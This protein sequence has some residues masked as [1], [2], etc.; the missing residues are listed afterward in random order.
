MSGAAAGIVME[1]WQQMVLLLLAAALIS[2][3][4][5]IVAGPQS[6]KAKEAEDGEEK[7]SSQPLPV[8]GANFTPA[9]LQELERAKGG[10]KR[11]GQRKG[12][13]PKET[14]AAAEEPAEEEDEEE[15]PAEEQ[16]LEPAP[17]VEV[18][19]PKNK[20]KGGEAP[21][22]APAKPPVPA[23]S[24]AKVAPP[25]AKV[26][27]PAAKEAA[28]AP[29]KAAKSAPAPAPVVEVAER[30]LT[31]DQKAAQ[32]EVRKVQKKLR[33]IAE[34]KAKRS[35]GGLTEAQ[36]AKIHQE[37]GL[38]EALRKAEEA[39]Q[40][41]LAAAAAQQD[42]ALDTPGSHSTG[43]MVQELVPEDLHFPDEAEQ[44]DED[45]ETGAKAKKKK[46]RKD[47][48]KI[49]QEEAEP[50]V[51]EPPAPE[52]EEPEAPVEEEEEAAVEE[53]EEAAAEEEEEAAAE[54]VED[55]A[56]AAE[57]EEDEDEEA[58]DEPEEPED[59]AA[60]E[61]EPEEVEEEAA[62]EEEEA[63]GAEEAAEDNEVT[64]EV[65]PEEADDSEEAEEEAAPA[66]AEPPKVIV[67]P[68]YPPTAREKE[69]M[70]VQKKIREIE[71]LE[72][73]QKSGTKLL[74]NQEQKLTK[75][76]GHLEELAI[77]VNSVEPHTI[78]WSAT[79]VDVMT[80][81]FGVLLKV[82]GKSETVK[83]SAAYT[84][85]PTHIDDL[86]TLAEKYPKGAEIKVRI[87]RDGVL[88][89]EMSVDDEDIHYEESLALLKELEVL[90]KKD[91]KM[92]Q[93][94][95]DTGTWSEEEYTGPIMS[96]RDGAI[97]VRVGGHREVRIAASDLSSSLVFKDP[98]SKI[99]KTRREEIVIGQE[100]SFRLRYDY[101]NDKLFGSMIA[102]VGKKEERSDSMA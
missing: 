85:P 23:P 33:E 37:P 11:R 6:R 96:V 17:V 42:S 32:S 64:A 56:A 5:Y 4:G 31:A 63:A 58:E 54:E 57:D 25:A 76:A 80:P 98:V 45:F 90:T 81:M 19:K 86:A 2:L 83:M 8:F 27:P 20:K 101:R 61:D 51:P 36:M 43:E 35:S 21:P 88:V 34:L 46:N 53:E 91:E 12:S 84:S 9:A 22:A 92:I 95:Y 74:A 7:P 52:P 30:E 69:I 73:K 15:E 78:E 93:V 28:A 14:P 3:F 59:E 68:V 62:A 38:N 99:V 24:L 66:V 50:E 47:K 82:D 97:F 72:A 1:G 65:A 77:W 39:F 41:S 40:A 100:V 67:R 18:Q 70:K 49:Q 16:V 75:K 60:A 87:M 55:P 94:L 48:K 10:R 13:A 71:D 79:V 89:T 29:A 26:A 44:E 102:Q